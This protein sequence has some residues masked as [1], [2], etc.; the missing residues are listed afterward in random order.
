MSV[1]LFFL[2]DFLTYFLVGVIV[3]AILAIVT[4]TDVS[5]KGLFNTG[6]FVAVVRLLMLIYVVWRY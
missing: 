2:K 1:F 3:R 6:I 4:R 5:G